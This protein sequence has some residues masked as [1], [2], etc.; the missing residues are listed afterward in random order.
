[1]IFLG[2]C[3]I[4]GDQKCTIRTYGTDDIHI[5][6]VPCLHCNLQKVMHSVVLWEVPPIQILHYQIWYIESEKHFSHSKKS[7]W[8]NYQWVLS[9]RIRVFGVVI[10]LVLARTVP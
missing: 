10:G 6:I 8:R 7:T 3:D 4:H 5:Q 2:A 1:M 9:N